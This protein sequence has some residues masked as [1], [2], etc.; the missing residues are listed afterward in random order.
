[1]N[2]IVIAIPTYKRTEMLKKLILSI[3]DCI[4]NKSIIG[5]IRIIVVDNDIEKSAEDTVKNLLLENPEIQNVVY[6][7]FTQK[8]LSNVRNEMLR[9]SFELNPDFI[10][11]IDDDEFVSKEWLNEMV[12]TI[13]TNEAD[14]ARGPVFVEIAENTPDYISCWFDRENYP[15]NSRLDKL[16]SGNLIMRRTS[17]QKF[18][19]W[20]D[21]RFNT[22]GSEDSFFGI[23]L[24]KKDAKIYWAAKAITYETIPDKRANLSWLLKRN[25]RVAGTFI[26]ILKVEKE[27]FK[28][29]KKA[30]IS[31]IYIFIGFFATVLMLLPIKRRYWGILKLSEGLGGIAGLGNKIYSEYK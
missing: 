27:Y 4:I 3:K 19:I 25:Y 1:M 30:I 7:N 28:L 21:N 11:F 2:K 8:G 29:V 22:I 17:L 5:E 20:F 14:I 9:K 18:G 13:I 15:D 31:L 10:V 26:Y 24:L 12:K 16:S 23:Q 6:Y